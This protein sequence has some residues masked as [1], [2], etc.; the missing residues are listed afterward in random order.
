MTE[1]CC[2]VIMAGGKGERFWPL[3]TRSRP[4]QLLSLVG[5]EP[6]LSLA[7]KRLEGLIPL[8]NIFIITRDELTEAVRQTAPELPGENI[9]GEPF[10]RD[11]AAACAL[12]AALVKARD[13]EAVFCVLTADH[14]IEDIP[15]FQKT[16]AES[17]K[18]A[19]SSDVLI[20]IGIKPG[21]PSTGFGYIEAGNALSE[22]D[23]IEFAAARR[24][25]E[26]PDR[27]TAGKYLEKGNYY[28]NSGMFVW[29]VN[30]FLKALKEFEPPL[31]A[32]SET[33]ASHAGKEDFQDMLETEYSKLRKISVDYAVM[34]KARNIV[35]VKGLFDWD[36]VGSWPA[37]ENHFDK[38]SSGN[39]LIGRC[40]TIDA[41]GN[42]VVSHNRVTALMGVR[43]L[44]VVHAENA[45]LVCT[46]ERAQEVKAMVKKLS[47]D[48]TCGDVL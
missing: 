33:M 45:T 20:T 28:W 2:A 42:I 31:Y 13:P 7:V 43:G 47:E 12:G 48:N 40:K 37:L 17:M 34:E 15:I 41:E 27:A 38:D 46:R 23:G 44:I 6:L 32:M 29:S 39:I 19:S 22:R 9:V 1:K 14:I 36:D 8:R 16:L 25:V 21:F 11:T 3:S 5:D 30:S 35:V 10:G 18:T 24:F 4:K 26:K